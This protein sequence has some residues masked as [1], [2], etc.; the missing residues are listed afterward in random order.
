MRARRANITRRSRHPLNRR[1]VVDRLLRAAIRVSLDYR[2]LLH[3]SRV[4]LSASLTLGPGC[5]PRRHRF[6]VDLGVTR[7]TAL[8][9]AVAVRAQGECL[10]VWRGDHVAVR[11]LTVRRHT[12]LAV[13]LVRWLLRHVV[14][15]WRGRL[16]CLL[17]RERRPLVNWLDTH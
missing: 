1:H 9:T 7:L 11:L 14:R 2:S 3:R 6:H 5:G 10:E 17:V 4:L 15:R 8:D 13:R 16:E 12:L